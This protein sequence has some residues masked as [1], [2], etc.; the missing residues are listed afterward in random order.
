MIQISKRH[1]G[2]AIFEK[3]T[4]PPLRSNQYFPIAVAITILAVG[5]IRNVRGEAL[6]AGR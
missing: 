2:P 4:E 3:A 5:I 1:Y 6:G